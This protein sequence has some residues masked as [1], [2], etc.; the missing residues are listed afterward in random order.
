MKQLGVHLAQCHCDHCG[1][2]RA[3]DEPLAVWKTLFN[4]QIPRHW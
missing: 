2:T 4:S 3:R 1:K